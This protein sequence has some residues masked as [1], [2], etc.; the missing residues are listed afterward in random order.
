MPS[1]YRDVSLQDGSVGAVH[2]SDDEFVFEPSTLTAPTTLPWSGVLAANGAGRRVVLTRRGQG[3]LV[4]KLDTEEARL[5]L[6]SDIRQHIGQEEEEEVAIS[7][8]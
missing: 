6:Q 4:L 8:A 1:S 2:L 3:P 7:D 5:Q